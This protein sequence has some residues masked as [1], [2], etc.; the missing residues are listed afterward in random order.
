MATQWL[1]T[2]ECWQNVIDEYKLLKSFFFSCWCWLSCCDKCK[3]KK[4][5]C[6]LNCFLGIIPFYKSRRISNQLKKKKNKN[7]KLLQQYQ[8]KVLRFVLF[9]LKQQKKKFFKFIK[10][11]K[12]EKS[13]N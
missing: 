1:T 7:R 5:N 9:F 2:V 13:R 8:F 10:N 6:L 11:L 4:K 12:K 3:N